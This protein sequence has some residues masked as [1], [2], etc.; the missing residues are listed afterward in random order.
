VILVCLDPIIFPCRVCKENTRGPRNTP[1]VVVL[2][3]A[4][5][6]RRHQAA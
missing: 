2:G 3:V 1:V 5:P 6:P 4:D